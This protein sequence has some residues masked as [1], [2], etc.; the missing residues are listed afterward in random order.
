ME[1]SYRRGPI[2]QAS[3]T[4]GGEARRTVSEP[5]VYLYVRYEKG[6]RFECVTRNAQ[7]CANSV[8]MGADL[9]S[10]GS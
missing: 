5:D 10:V 9:N 3:R 8:A 7:V 6:S 4:N 2:R 1:C